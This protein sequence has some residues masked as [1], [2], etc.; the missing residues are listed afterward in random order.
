MKNFIKN[1]FSKEKSIDCS[2]CGN[3]EKE[4]LPL[5]DFYRENMEKYGYKYFYQGEMTAHQTYQ[6]SVCGAS[7]RER[8]YAYWLKQKLE[9][10]V[11]LKMI[12]F[13]PEHTLSNWI[14]QNYK[15]KY[16]TA[17]LMMEGVDHKV[18]MLDMPFE[19]T[20]FDAFICSHVLE[21]VDDD[22]KAVSELYRILKPNGWGILMAPV[23][24]AITHTQE[25]KSHTTE[26]E[27]WRYYGQNDHVRLYS[28]DG[29][30][31]AISSSGFKVYQLGIEHFGKQIFKKL[32]LKES[33]ILYIVEKK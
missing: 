33:S 30:V 16:E 13:A 19:D 6:C 27:R 7:D 2:I 24:T 17:D 1:L 5:S 28:H 18:D 14:K 11:G 8:L 25:D 26:E 31:E 9:K 15:F 21:H 23:C 10:Q 32:G 22:K 12:H 3:R 20:S 29:F 4:Y